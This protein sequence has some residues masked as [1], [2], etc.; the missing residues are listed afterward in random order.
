[1]T[2][3][4]GTL[5]TIERYEG[6]LPT[7]TSSNGEQVAESFL[8][9]LLG[10]TDK[11]I[12][13]SIFAFGLEELGQIA[14]LHEDSVRELIFSAGILG[15]GRSASA[16]I[17]QLEDERS[18]ITRNPRSEEQKSRLHRLAKRRDEIGAELR[19]A[20]QSA[21]TFE[22]LAREIARE[23]RQVASGLTNLLGIEERRRELGDLDVASGS[24]ETKAKLE[25]RLRQCPT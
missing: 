6:K 1:V 18:E 21:K 10:H 4:N 20:K 7:I 13:E 23:Q 12:F 24:L 19:A 25:E 2:D 5:W 15:A 17:K 9:D 14:L 22:R 3:D 8:Q 16:A 11:K